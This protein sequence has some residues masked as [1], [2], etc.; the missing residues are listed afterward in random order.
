MRR[1]YLATILLTWFFLFA[2][3]PKGKPIGNTTSQ[4]Q[5]VIQL[6]TEEQASS[7]VR[8]KQPF[9]EMRTQ[10][11]L[12]EEI[13]QEEKV[14]SVPLYGRILSKVK[15]SKTY[16]NPSVGEEV[17]IFFSL[18]QPAK[19]TLSLYDPDNGLI[20]T[21]ADRK[22]K[23]AGRA[24]IIWD[25]RDQDKII[26]PDEAYYFTIKIEAADGRIEIYD[27]TIF[28]GGIENDI[29]EAD[30]DAE[31]QTINYKL[32]QMGRVCIRMGTRGGPLL[33]TLV[34]W[35]PRVAG[36]ITESWNGKDKDNVIDLINEPKF[37]MLITSFTFPENSI[38]TYGNNDYS[39]REYKTT[40]ATARPI[41]KE[42]ARKDESSLNISLHYRLPRTIDFTPQILISFPKSNPDQDDIPL[43]SGKSLVKVELDERDKPYFINQQF[44]V[45]FF[46]DNEFYTEAE[47][48]YLPYN[49]LWDLNSV[50]EGKHILTVNVSTFRDQIGTCTKKIRVAK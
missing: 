48:G 20:K 31:S 32:P 13:G 41:K 21:I 19:V 7:E 14:E 23:K 45:C 38:I 26:V 24:T 30:I 25:G 9:T 5:Q 15:I 11:P 47:M 44:E 1:I 18:S 28:S 6:Q 3:I 40:M 22:M 35:K 39:F 43:L 36:E 37:K 16:F 42:R 17:A 50:K 8:T 46:L 10:Q 27:P 4:R 12:M 29:T 2:C 34:D 49:W 33:N